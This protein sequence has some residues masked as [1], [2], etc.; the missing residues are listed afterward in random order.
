[1]FNGLFNDGHGD[2]GQGGTPYGGCNCTWIL[3]ILLFWCNVLLIA[4]AVNSQS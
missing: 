3:L 4:N 2:C 1:M